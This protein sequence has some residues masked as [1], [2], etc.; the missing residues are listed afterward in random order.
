M[1]YTKRFVCLAKSWRPGGSCVA[2]KEVLADGSF[3]NWIRPISNHGEEGISQEELTKRSGYELKLGDMVDITFAEHSPHLHQ[4]EN[5]KI[6]PNIPWGDQYKKTADELR[7]AVDHFEG[8]LWHNGT[9][10]QH[11]MNDEVPEIYLQG[12]QHSL[13]LIQVPELNIQIT[14]TPK[15]DGS[16]KRTYRGDFTLNGVPYSFRITDPTMHWR[17]NDRTAQRYQYIGPLLCI[18]LSG[19]FPETRC[20]HKLIASVIADDM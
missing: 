9:S 14:H 16:T 15:A 20:A 6:A 19:V 7:A 11:G 2:G 8:I 18:S 5:H 13:L 1:T 17:I 12:F 10:S 3:G 4:V